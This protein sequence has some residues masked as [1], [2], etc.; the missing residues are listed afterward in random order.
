VRVSQDDR[1]LFLTYRLAENMGSKTTAVSLQLMRLN[2]IENGNSIVE[3][4]PCQRL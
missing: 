2:G 3:A 1:Q 4:Y